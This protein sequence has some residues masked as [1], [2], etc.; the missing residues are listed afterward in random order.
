M[1][2]TWPSLNMRVQ[3]TEAPI[4]SLINVIFTWYFFVISEAWDPGQGSLLFGL[5]GVTG[6]REEEV[7]TL[8]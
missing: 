1:D 7:L 2:H 8:K 4:N 6:T 5:K 3:M